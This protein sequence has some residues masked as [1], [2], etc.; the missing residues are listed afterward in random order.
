MVY[1]RALASD[2]GLSDATKAVL[3]IDCTDGSKLEPLTLTGVELSKS[4]YAFV[5]I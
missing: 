5:Q 2:V 1:F 4:N 3:W